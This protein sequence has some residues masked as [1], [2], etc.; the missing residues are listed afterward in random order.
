MKGK[1]SVGAAGLTVA[2][3]LS[4][5]VGVGAV[6]SSTVFVVNSN[7]DGPGSFRRA[8]LAASGDAQITRIQFLNHVSTVHLRNTVEFAGSQGLTINGSGATLDGAKAPGP[9]FVATGGGDLAV[10]GLTVR[11]A[12]TEGIL[13]EVP[14]SATGTIRVS[15]VN[16]NISNNRGHGVLVNDQVDSSTPE[17]AEPN[18]NGS[19]ASRRGVRLQLPVQPQRLQRVGSRRPSRQRRRGRRPRHHGQILRGRGEWR[20]RHRSRRT[21]SRGRPRRNAR[22]ASNRERP[23]RPGGSRRWVRYRRIQRR[24]HPRDGHLQPGERQSRGRLRLQRESTTATCA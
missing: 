19:A 15:L 6:P 24:Q 23:V 1:M 17:D 2:L 7:D 9:A 11:N 20:R 10:T 13:V 8:I 14:P 18:P 5:M 4:T 21:R 22:H 16:V 3:A 12:Q